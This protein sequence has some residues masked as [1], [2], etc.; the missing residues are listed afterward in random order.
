[1]E[2]SKSNQL[3]TTSKVDVPLFRETLTAFA[4]LQGKHLGIED[5]PRTLPEFKVGIGNFIQSSIQSAL[6]QNHRSYLAYSELAHAKYLENQA[7][8]QCDLKQKEINHLELKLEKS[9][10]EAKRL[11]PRAVRR[12]L[13]RI[14]FAGLAF[15]AVTDG[16]LSYDAFRYQSYPVFVAIAA[17]CMVT[18]L[19][20]GSHFLPKYVKAG[21][22]ARIRMAR[23]ALIVTLYSLGFCVISHFRSHAYSYHESLGVDITPVTPAVNEFDFAVISTL[24]FMIAFYVTLQGWKTQEEIAQEDDYRAVLKEMEE[25]SREIGVLTAERRKLNSEAGTALKDATKIFED[26]KSAENALISSWDHVISHFGIVNSRFRK[27]VPD[28]ISNYP[29]PFFKTY[30]Q[31]LNIQ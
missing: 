6:D 24:G 15:V 27:T 7:K 22:T 10:A 1:M 20:L 14:A 9:K 30:F 3:L 11:K 13:R 18:V 19:I 26:A 17:S 8:I 16:I 21:S 28:I 12:W 31:T 2:E 25:I 29:S 4:E 5:R 23:H